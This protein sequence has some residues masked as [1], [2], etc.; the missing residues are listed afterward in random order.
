MAKSTLKLVPAT[1][2]KSPSPPRTLAEHGSNLWRSVHAEYGIEDAGGVEL[3]AQA[4]S[5]L[6]RA[7]ECAG[8]IASDGVVI[9]MAV[10]TISRQGR[11]ATGVRVMNLTPGTSISAVGGTRTRSG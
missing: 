7:E 5:A 11:P 4:C 1:P 2:S 9:R 6:D 8:H 10:G 3:L